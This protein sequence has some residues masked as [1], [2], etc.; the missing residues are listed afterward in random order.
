MHT[1]IYPVDCK[2][3]LALLKK[4]SQQLHMLKDKHQEVSWLLADCLSHIA[5]LVDATVNGRKQ[6]REDAEAVENFL[7]TMRFLFGAQALSEC[8]TS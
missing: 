7:E 8:K 1:K 6:S 2:E 5:A 3:M 4:V